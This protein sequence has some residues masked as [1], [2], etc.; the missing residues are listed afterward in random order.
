M[1]KNK[2][3]VVVIPAYNEA[4]HIAGVIAKIPKE[5]EQ[6]IVVDDCSED[7]T[8]EVVL[9]V[10]DER[11]KLIKHE[12]NMGVGGAM[13]TGYKESL[14]TGV[15]IVVKIDGDGQMNA[16]EIS[17]VVAPIENDWS[18]YCKGFRFHDPRNLKQMPKVRL[19]GNIALSFFTKITSG[20]WNI[21]DPT[22]GFTAIH[23]TALSCIDL[24]ILD[25]GYFFETDMLMQLNRMN[26]VVYDV[27][28]SNRYGNEQSGLNPLHISATFPGLLLKAFAKRILW[29]YFI[30]DFTVASLFII[31]G[32][33]LFLFGIGFGLYH[34]I[35][36]VM[37]DVDTP[38]GTVM[39]A[40][41]TLF[42]GFQFLLQAIVLDINNVPKTPLQTRL[43]A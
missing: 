18:D 19:I 39:I 20:Y 2:T 23:K 43:K 31:T 11:V 33:P 32:L 24:D 10:Q 22:S 25:K 40:V 13:I 6:I 3:I 35:K 12:R 4:N 37:A 21:F 16:E 8:S 5:V 30:R 26:A 38:T 7:N 41:V 17:K 1:H 36:N 9:G 27:E 42:F 14:R 34:W 28:I 15:D 29:S